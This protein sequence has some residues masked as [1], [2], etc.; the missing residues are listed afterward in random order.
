[1][2]SFNE[3]LNR[4][5][6]NDIFEFNTNPEL[7]DIRS[8]YRINFS[9]IVTLI[10]KLGHKIALEDISGLDITLSQRIMESHL[11]LNEINKAIASGELKL[12][13]IKL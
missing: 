11:L 2:D 7:A 5:R 3:Q 6:R 10:K 9:I 4:N 12:N 8:L 13:D 1:M